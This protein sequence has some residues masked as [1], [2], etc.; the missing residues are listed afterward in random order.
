[1]SSLHLSDEILMAFADGELDEAMTAAVEQA[2]RS[3]PATLARVADFVRSR[4]IARGAFLADIAPAASPELEE[5]VLAQIRAVEG[6]GSVAEPATAPLAPQRTDRWSR[7][8]LPLAA[9][10]AALI[11]GGFGYAVGMR[12]SPR[13]DHA[14]LVASLESSGVTARLDQV[15]SGQE[16]DVAGG[17]LRVISTMRMAN[18]DLCRE[19]EL[20]REARKADAVACRGNE[21]WAVTFAVMGRDATSYTPAAGGD[22]V[23]TY[24]QNAG[25]GAPLTGEDEVKALSTPAR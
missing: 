11:A 5:A 19:F 16:Q 23:S 7:R 1:M 20:K 13:L 2:M 14:G 8:M 17:R 21:G 22:L 10:L 6:G 24:L 18:G 15:A 3:D 12:S 25:A 9:S 4:R